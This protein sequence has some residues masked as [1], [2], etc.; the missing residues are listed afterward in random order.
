MKWK[1]SEISA[2]KPEKPKEE[3]FDEEHYSPWS[4]R[5]E[6][7]KSTFLTK[8]PVAIIIPVV[9]IV[10]L[11]VALLVV[12]WRGQG[13][14]LSNPAIAE[15]QEKLRLT[16]ERLDKFEAID[17]KV[18]RIWEQAKTFEQFKERFDRS[19][20][21]STLR[22]DHLTM[23]M[24]ALQKQ[25]AEMRKP[26]P[27]KAVQ[28]AAESKPVKQVAKPARNVDKPDKQD[29][30]PAQTVAKPAQPA[31]KPVPAVTATGTHQVAAGE[32]FYGISRKYGMSVKELQNVNN[33]SSDA[34]LQ[35]GQKL[36]VKK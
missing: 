31:A 20:A 14:S 6:P 34:V 8:M 2:E 22:M 15:L 5:K 3:S 33:L 11:V 35:I 19:E 30:V 9:V 17:E 18:T 27:A 10:A 29:V 23:S 4:E 1:D 28:A 12:L 24:E 16:Q 7:L 25:L 26:A 36:K 32:T 13:D 21:S